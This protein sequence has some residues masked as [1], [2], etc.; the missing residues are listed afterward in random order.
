MTS[1]PSPATGR[2][3]RRGPQ[4]S[5]RHY[6]ARS[7]AERPIIRRTASPRRAPR[8]AARHRRTARRSPTNGK[9]Y[10]RHRARSRTPTTTTWPTMPQAIQALRRR[11]RR[12][13]RR[14]VAIPIVDCTNP[15]NRPSGTLPVKGFGCFFLLQPV[16]QRGQRRLDLRPVHRRVRRRAAA[17]ASTGGHGTLQDRPAQRP[18]QPRLMRR[19]NHAMRR[20]IRGPRRSRGIA[21]VEF[22]ITVPMLLF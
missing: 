5:F 22:V 3:D 13:E 15:V 2:A 17:R 12:P 9:P 19:A 14:V 11:R 18:G 10:Q 6:A 4:H 1:T 21:A 20:E 8:T 16:E 7:V